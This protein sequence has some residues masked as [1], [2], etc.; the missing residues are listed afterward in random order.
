[1]LW[2]AFI[3]S[4]PLRMYTMYFVLAAL[5]LGVLRAAGM[6]KFNIAYAQSVMLNE[7]L[8]LLGLA[9]CA[10]LLGD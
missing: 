10:S 7:N 1:M 3:L 8:Q 2:A 6:P 4:L 5:V 9:A